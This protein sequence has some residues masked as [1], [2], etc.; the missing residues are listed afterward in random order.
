MCCYSIIFALLSS[1][2]LGCSKTN[3]LCDRVRIIDDNVEWF[4]CQ[5]AVLEDDIPVSPDNSLIVYADKR[6]FGL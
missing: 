2:V 4:D 3:E 5:T 1:S 6:C